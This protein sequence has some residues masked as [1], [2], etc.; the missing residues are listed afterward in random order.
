MVLSEEVY[1]ILRADLAKLVDLHF[2]HM[3]NGNAKQA[4]MYV[5]CSPPVLSTRLTITHRMI[6]NDHLDEAAESTK[7]K[8]QWLLDLE[9][10]PTTLNTHYYADYKDKFLSYYKAARDNTDLV[11]K[12]QRDRRMYEGSINKALSGLSEIGITAQ[13][14]DLPKLLPPDPMEAALNIMASVR[15]Y[16]QGS[17]Q[18]PGLKPLHR[19]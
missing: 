13:A 4:I 10:N 14:T 11:T 15:A 17:V 7:Q 3:G 5:T 19:A 12:L 16:F 1:A 18:G 9:R 2:E 8:I 6:V